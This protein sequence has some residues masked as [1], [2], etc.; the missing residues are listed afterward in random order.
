MKLMDIYFSL[1]S[2]ID[3]VERRLHDEV[4]TPQRNLKKASTHLLKAGGKRIRP[5][6]VL[7]AGKFGNYD[8]DRLTKVA[9]ALQLI[10]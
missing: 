8:V 10:H 3:V 5:I 2:D 7:L 4:H 1:K 6:F 9:T